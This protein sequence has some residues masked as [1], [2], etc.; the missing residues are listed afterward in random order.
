MLIQMLDQTRGDGDMGRTQSERRYTRRGGLH[1]HRFASSGFPE[2]TRRLRLKFAVLLIAPACHAPAL[3][4]Q[5]M[6]FTTLLR[7]AT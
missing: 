5:T 7:W 2:R 1:L 6:T 3:L 4:H